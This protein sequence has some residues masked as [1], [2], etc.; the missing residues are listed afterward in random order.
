MSLVR[1]NSM[2]KRGH[3]SNLYVFNRFEIYGSHKRLGQY[4]GYA[5]TKFQCFKKVRR[6]E[7]KGYK[8]PSMFYQDLLNCTSRRD[9]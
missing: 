4:M 5:S 7:K 9:Y 8:V 6:L 2:A 1:Y 3:N